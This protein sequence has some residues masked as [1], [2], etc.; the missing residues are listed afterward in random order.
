MYWI[1]VDFNPYYRVWILIVIDKVFHGRYK[2]NNMKI[3]NMKINNKTNNRSVKA[4]CKKCCRDCVVGYK[5]QD[6]G[7]AMVWTNEAMLEARDAKWDE[8]L[9]FD[10][11]IC[12]VCHARQVRENKN[13]EDKCICREAKRDYWRN[14]RENISIKEQD[15][16]TTISVKKR[17]PLP[18]SC[19]VCFKNAQNRCIECEEPF[20]DFELF[21]NKKIGNISINESYCKSCI[22]KQSGDIEDY[23]TVAVRVRQRG[24][25]MHR[26]EAR[27][28]F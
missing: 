2:I 3:N 1:T 17:L 4:T 11:N 23:V 8:W 13:I 26:T 10:N 25:I 9:I 24:K 6:T 19:L 15:G 14:L 12:F 18:P 27:A 16:N 20:F 22:E 7:Q 21:I 5:D 28:D